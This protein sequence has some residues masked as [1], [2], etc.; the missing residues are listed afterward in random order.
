MHGTYRI[1]PGEL[2]QQ[3]DGFEVLH[4][5]EGEIAEIVARR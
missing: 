5:S 4:Q 2:V 3:F 1:A